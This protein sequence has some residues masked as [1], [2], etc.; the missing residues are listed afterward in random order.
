MPH[1]T[2][3]CRELDAQLSK[4]VLSAAPDSALLETPLDRYH[5]V[6]RLHSARVESEKKRALGA[7]QRERD[8]TAFVQAWHSKV[9][10]ASMRMGASGGGGM[11]GGGF[12]STTMSNLGA[13]LSSRS[14]HDR[15]FETH[16][17][18]LAAM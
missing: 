17:Y 4:H 9:A 8:R 13:S 10:S 11:G 12:A 16:G 2:R 7:S 18:G 3:R 6:E 5:R 14:Q 1:Q 15:Q